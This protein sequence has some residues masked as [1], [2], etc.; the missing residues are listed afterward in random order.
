MMTTKREIDRIVE[1]YSDM[2]LRIALHHIHNYAQVQDIVQDAFIKFCINLLN[3]KVGKGKSMAYS[4][5]KQ[6]V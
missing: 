3:L 1:K 6:F 5:H 2:L 4:C